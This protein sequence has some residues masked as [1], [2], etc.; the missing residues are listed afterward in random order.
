MN[1]LANPKLLPQPLRLACSNITQLA[2]IALQ[3]IILR[4]R[5]LRQAC[6]D[7]FRCVFV[8]A[9]EDYVGVGACV[10]GECF[11]STLYRDHVKL[12]LQRTCL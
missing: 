12:D 4:S 7:L 5:V 10:A 9:Y 8:P 1:Y 2:R 11:G 6:D 3:E